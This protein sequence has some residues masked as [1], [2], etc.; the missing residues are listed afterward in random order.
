[1]ADVL[2]PASQGLYEL[3][4]YTAGMRA[5]ATHSFLLLQEQ[6]DDSEALDPDEVGLPLAWQLPALA[7]AATSRLWRG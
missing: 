5:P 3:E 7:S 2:L 4:P 6:D 1:M